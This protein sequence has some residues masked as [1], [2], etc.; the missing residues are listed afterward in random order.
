MLSHPRR[1]V[2]APRRLP[3]EIGTRPPIDDRIHVGAVRRKHVDL[4]LIARQADRPHLVGHRHPDNARRGRHAATTGL[5]R[6]PISADLDAN[7]I[8]G[9]EVAGR[10]ET[11][12]H[13][14]RCAGRDDVARLRCDRLGDERDDLGDGEDPCRSTTHQAQ[15]AR[16]GRPDPEGRRI[17]S[18]VRDDRERA[19]RRERVQALAPDRL[20]LGGLEVAGADVVEDGVGANVREGFVDIDAPEQR[21]PITTAS[22]PS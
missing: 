7:R 17:E 15:L 22:S 6:T 2:R 13:A 16:H 12:A 19:R 9:R 21:R 3:E 5:V 18:R 11:K 10:I 14:G 8:A 20:R 1:E 4:Q